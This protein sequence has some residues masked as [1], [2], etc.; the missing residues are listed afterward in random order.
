MMRDQLRKYIG[1]GCVIGIVCI[2]SGCPPVQ[3]TRGPFPEPTP[4]AVPAEMGRLTA[5][6]AYQQGL[7]QFNQGMYEEAIRYFQLAIERN[8]SHL[9]AYLGLGDVYSMQNKY[10]MAETY[11][12]KVLQYD[13]Y[14]IPALTA[15]GNMQWKMGNYREALSFYRKVLEIDPE[16]QFTQH[17]I[18]VVTRELFNLYYEQGIAAKEA[19]DL[20]SAAIEW[21]K[22]YSLY[23]ENQDFAVEIG[24]L[25]LQQQDYMMADGYFQQVLSNDPNYVAALLGAGKVQLALKHYD[26]AINYF[27]QGVNLR[28]G[29]PEAAGL[30]Q[31]AQAEKLSS[32]LPPEYASIF[33]SAQV[34]RGDIAALLMVE[35]TLED[36]LQP[37]SRLAIIS[38]ITTHWAKPYI[39]KVVQLGI[40]QIFPDRSF[41]PYDPIHKGELAFVLDT[42]FKRLAIPLPNVSAVSFSD[43][44][45]DNMYHDSVLRVY[46]AGLIAAT[47]EGAFG[48]N[49]PVSGEEARQIFDK[50]KSMIWYEK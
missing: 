20:N 50:L 6:W 7:Q 45:Q 16:N 5:E 3:E 21:Q 17:Q 24:Y 30:L 25:F 40:M 26:E 18:E 1:I 33:T 39:I 15:L 13:P 29:D 44:H 27:R 48:F 12:N 35:L 46:A 8:Q 38:D 23:P 10:L 2:I 28:P 14:S 32:T 37:S 42:L 43:V 22:A 36:R 41:L 31:Q 19:G 34:T 11:Y 4:E 9:R 49:D 47:T